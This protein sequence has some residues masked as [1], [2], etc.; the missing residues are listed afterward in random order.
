MYLVKTD[1]VGLSML[2]F[3][4]IPRNDKVKNDDNDA[5]D[6]QKSVIRFSG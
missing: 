1:P 3:L 6:E 2:L 4:S 5:D